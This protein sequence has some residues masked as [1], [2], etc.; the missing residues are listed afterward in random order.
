[1]EYMKEKGLVGAARDAADEV[2]VSKGQAV[3]GVQGAGAGVREDAY[4]NA[5][6]QCTNVHRVAI[7]SPICAGIPCTGARGRG[8]GGRDGGPRSP[9]AQGGVRGAGG[10]G[11]EQDCSGGL[12]AVA[13]HVPPSAARLLICSSLLLAHSSHPALHPAAC[14]CSRRWTGCWP[15]APS[16]PRWRPP[17]RAW[18]R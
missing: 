1:M 7:S 17:S 8:Q 3:G 14:R 5:S 18:P 12:G 2:L 10:L 16:A 11:F 6:A 4:Q 15:T 13:A 9:G